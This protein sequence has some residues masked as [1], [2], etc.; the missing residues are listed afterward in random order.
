[1]LYTHTQT[2]IYIFLWVLH[3]EDMHFEN[4]LRGSTRIIIIDSI[5]SNYKLHVE[6]IKSSIKENKNS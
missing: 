1:M 4:T 3:T 2:Y 5:L 6:Y